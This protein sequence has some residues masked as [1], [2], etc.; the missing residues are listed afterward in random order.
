MCLFRERP[1]NKTFTARPP[2]KQHTETVYIARQ[3]TIKQQKQLVTNIVVCEVAHEDKPT[4]KYLISEEKKTMY[5]S[6]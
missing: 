5:C 4:E 3:P 1:E 2:Y 6:I